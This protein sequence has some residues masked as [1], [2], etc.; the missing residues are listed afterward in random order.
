MPEVRTIAVAVD[1]SEPAKAALDW[2]VQFAK[3]A[4]AS[5]SIVGVMP[6]PTVYRTWEGEV[7]ESHVEERRYMPELLDRYVDEARRS[8]VKPVE[9]VLLE[10]PVVDKLLNFLDEQRPDLMVM[11]ARGLSTARRIFLGSV[12]EA[13]VHHAKGTIVVVRSPKPPGKRSG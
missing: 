9:P 5:L 3:L 8:G 7:I 12:S 10:G 11:G 4:S 2:A 1:G 6:A 13:V